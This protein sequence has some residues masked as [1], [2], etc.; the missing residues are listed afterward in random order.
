MGGEKLQKLLAQSNGPQRLAEKIL[1]QPIKNISLGEILGGSP[2]L[3]RII[4]SKKE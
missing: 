1:R 4:F 2:D 3:R